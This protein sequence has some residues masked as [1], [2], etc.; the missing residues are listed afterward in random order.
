MPVKITPDPL[1]KRPD[2]CPH[3][4]HEVCTCSPKLQETA[5]SLQ[6]LIEGDDLYQ[7]MLTDIASAQKR[8]EIPVLLLVPFFFVLI[9]SRAE[10]ETLMDRGCRFLSSDCWPSLCWAR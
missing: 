3:S 10:W 9:G 5:D 4:N 2:S 8:M 6:L 1:Y 7:A